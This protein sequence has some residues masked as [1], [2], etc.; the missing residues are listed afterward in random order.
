MI[1]L[2]NKFENEMNKRAFLNSLG[3]KKNVYQNKNKLLKLSAW[4]ILRF[5][6]NILEVNPH[7]T[8]SEFIC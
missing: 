2:A 8:T 7:F 5:I 4:M 6:L 3:E 1:S